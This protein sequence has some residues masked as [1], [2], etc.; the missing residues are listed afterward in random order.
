[1]TNKELNNICKVI[2]NAK[3]RTIKKILRRLNKMSPNDVASL[4]RLIQAV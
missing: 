3:Q 4:A 1:M 2:E